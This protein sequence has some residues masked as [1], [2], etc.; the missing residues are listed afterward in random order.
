VSTEPATAHHHSLEGGADFRVTLDG[1]GDSFTVGPRESI[2]GAGRRAGFWL[3][4]EC[5]WGSCG[6]CRATLVEGELI[7]LFPEA[8]A[9]DPRDARRRRFL[10]CQST[11]AGDVVIKPTSVDSA[12]PEERPVVDHRGTLREVRH[13]GPDIAEF[14]FELEPI[15][16]ALAVAQF[17]PGQYGVLELEPG[18]RR[19][20]SM[21]NL[22][23]SSDLQ[24]IAKRYEGRPGSNRLFEL[25]PGDTIPIELPYGDMWLR[26]RQRPALLI[27]G[28]TGISAILSLVRSINGDENWAKRPVHILYGAATRDELVCWDELQRLSAAMPNVN[29]HGALVTADDTWAGTR[30]LV[31]ETLAGLLNVD[32]GHDWSPAAGVVY[33][34]GPPPMVRA[35]QDVLA[36]NGIQ[37][38]RTHVDSFG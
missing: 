14:T 8:P 16:G 31:T 10:M 35:V 6:R 13:L 30:G 32:P 37:L 3:P 17:R 2:L 26:D 29:V 18:L 36:A 25:Q 33:L 5:G 9:I 23:G 24:F 27:A 22:P 28:G 38:D 20:Y 4:F 19:C 12:P 15:D 34:A 7:S 11:P 21:A 1:S